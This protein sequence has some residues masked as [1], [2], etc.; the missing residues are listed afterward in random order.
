MK[1]VFVQAMGLD[2]KPDNF[3]FK[4]AE[5]VIILGSWTTK[6]LMLDN[7]FFVAYLSFKV[8]HN[9]LSLGQI[10]GESFSLLVDH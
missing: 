6:K 10:N 1:V 8:I 9:L 7:T 2:I 3:A 4:L 5:V